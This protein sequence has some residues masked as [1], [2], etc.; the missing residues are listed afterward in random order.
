MQLV[1][2]KWDGRKTRFGGEA[3][4]EIAGSTVGLSCEVGLVR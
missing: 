1:G 4:W 3:S 2:S